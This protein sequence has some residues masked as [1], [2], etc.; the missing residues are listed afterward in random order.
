MTFR[1]GRGYRFTMGP[2]AD[3]ILWSLLTGPVLWCL[4]GGLVWGGSLA[5]AGDYYSWIDATGTMVITDDPGQSPPAANRSSVFLHQFEERSQVPVK[6]DLQPLTP[7]SSDPGSEGRPSNGQPAKFSSDV[8]PKNE[9][10]PPD[11]PLV[12]PAEAELPPIVVT[13]PEDAVKD[14]YRW[15][16]L[17]TPLYLT[18]GAIS[19]YWCHQNVT[20]PEDAFQR[21]LRIQRTG[22]S[23]QGP[24]VAGLG[25]REAKDPLGSRSGNAIYDQVVRERRALIERNAMLV[26][27]GGAF[28][29]SSTHGASGASRGSR[30]PV[31]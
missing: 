27:S 1:A 2:K 18:T 5:R 12:N 14:W 15:I 29:R 20:S 4:L 24:F 11:K 6:R 8:P 16:P 23:Q 17:T 3:T 19:G 9:L 22:L 10:P 25:Q 31:R 30:I 26:P 7:L 13:Q 21:F 28:S